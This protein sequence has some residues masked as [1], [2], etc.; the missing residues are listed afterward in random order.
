MRPRTSSPWTSSPQVCT[1]AAAAPPD[2]TWQALLFA[3]TL[4]VHG[5]AGGRRGVFLPSSA[6]KCPTNLTTACVAFCLS[7]SRCRPWILLDHA[8][9]PSLSSHIS[10]ETATSVITS[11]TPLSW[12]SNLFHHTHTCQS[13]CSTIKEAWTDGPWPLSQCRKRGRLLTNLFALGAL[14]SYS[15]NTYGTAPC[16]PP[17]PPPPPPPV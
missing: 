4:R 5:H 6:P 1:S 2:H 13:R 7:S 14:Y 9:P 10:R 15:L 17:V 8:R 12:T 11:F 3:M 16:A